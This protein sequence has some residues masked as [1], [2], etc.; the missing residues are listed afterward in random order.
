VIITFSADHSALLG[1]VLFTIFAATNGVLVAMG[2]AL[3]THVPRIRALSIGYGLIGIMSAVIAAIVLAVSPSPAIGTLVALVCAYAGSSGCLELYS[4]VRAFRASDTTSEASG[5]DWIF[6]GAITAALSI[7]V[8]FV[9]LNLRVP[10]T[11]QQGVEGFLTAPVVV[12]GLFGAYCAVI[13]VYLV[14]AGLSLKW[15]STTS[16][17][18]AAERVR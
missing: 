1:L 2:G 7:T 10:I 15:A 4:G 16:A 17:A 8:L 6:M 5:R 11:G 18:M 13:A 12:V 14:I 3:A 9:P